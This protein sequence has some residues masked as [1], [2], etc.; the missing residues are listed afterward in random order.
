MAAPSSRLYAVASAL[1]PVLSSWAGLQG[2]RVFNQRILSMLDYPETVCVGARSLLAA[3]PE[4][5]MRYTAEWHATGGLRREEGVI[6]CLLTVQ[7]GAAVDPSVVADRAA[8]LLGEVEQAIHAG[9]GTLNSVVPGMMW[10]HVSRAEFTNLVAE[11]GTATQVEFDV[12]Y[13][14]HFGPTV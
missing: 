13:R 8:V 1:P 2:V 14:G 7:T 4:D 10:C 5:T 11:G 12:Q 9:Y 3:G 6:A